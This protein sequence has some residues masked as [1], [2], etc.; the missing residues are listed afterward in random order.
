[1]AFL[2]VRLSIGWLFIVVAGIAWLILQPLV[3]RY[4]LLSGAT[5]IARAYRRYCLC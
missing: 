4:R 2:P 3:E 1:M 5:R